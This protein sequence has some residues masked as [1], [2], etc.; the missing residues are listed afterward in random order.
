[1]QASNPGVPPV[2]ERSIRKPFIP[3]KASSEDDVGFQ[4]PAPQR[5]QV[6]AVRSQALI[7]HSNKEIHSAGKCLHGASRRGAEW[8]TLEPG[9]VRNVNHL[10]VL[11]KKWLLIRTKLRLDKCAVLWAVSNAVLTACPQVVRPLCKPS[12]LHMHKLLACTH[13][14]SI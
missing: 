3:P 8:G 11:Q 13:T 14:T 10:N 9:L 4:Y 2:S 12:A 5:N 7:E 6:N 1:M